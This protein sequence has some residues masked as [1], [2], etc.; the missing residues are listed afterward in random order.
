MGVQSALGEGSAF[1][2]VLLEAS[3][4]APGVSVPR[5]RPPRPL[6]THRPLLPALLVALWLPAS[7]Q[8]AP[9]VPSPAASPVRAEDPVVLSPF[10]VGSE[11]E[12]GY[13]STAILQIGR[14]HV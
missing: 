5:G 3:P 10:Q 13:Q 2:T 4:I 9:N 6:M 8:V 11:S 12:R 7:A 1:A 14:A